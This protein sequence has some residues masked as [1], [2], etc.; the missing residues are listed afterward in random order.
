MQK[1]FAD[2]EIFHRLGRDEKYAVLHLVFVALDGNAFD[3]ID[4]VRYAAAQRTRDDM[5]VTMF[6]F[7]GVQLSYHL[8]II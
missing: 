5:I 1:M 8:I 2:F 3:G 7:D 6:A 4:E